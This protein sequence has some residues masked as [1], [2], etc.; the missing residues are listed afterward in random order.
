MN[1]IILIS[2]TL[3]SVIIA[4]L[5]IRYALSLKIYLKEFLNTSKKISNKE[6]N[7]RLN[8]SAKG[9][10]GNLSKNFNEMIEIM[11]T[12]LAQVEYEHLKMES[13]LKSISHGILAVD[14]N[15][16][17][18]L[19]N[20][21]AKVMLKC[22]KEQIVEGKDIV[23][24]IKDK[25]I[26]KKIMLIIGSKDSITKEITTSDDIV[27]SITL[28]PIYLQHSKNMI[29][30]SIINIK[31]VT[32]RVRLETMRSDFVANVTHELKTPL[33]SIS[34]FVETLKLN[35]NIDIQTRNRFLGIIESESDRLKK[36]INEILLLSFIEEKQ[37]LV[38]ESINVYDVFSEVYDITNQ[39]AEDKNIELTYEIKDKNENILSSKDYL[40]HIFINLIDNAI[41]YSPKDKKV[42]V[43]IE[44]DDNNFIFKVIDEGIGIPKEDLN[45]IFERFYRVNKARSQEVNGTGLGLAITKHIVK[46]LNGTIGVESELWEGSEFIVT[47]PKKNFLE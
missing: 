13:I 14:I 38:F 22:D 33:T 47:L 45:R 2:I 27:Y 25:D 41:K 39:L 5:S 44:F 10:L 12:T 43:V 32:E 23:N 40:R 16:N 30:G 21:K 7:T 17:I 6:F 35:E 18:I 19:I 11:D 46:N 24:A 26:L 20:E 29:I 31:D 28:D 8:I 1:E 34:G 9:E 37:D 4:I 36:L 3:T 15:S 42:H